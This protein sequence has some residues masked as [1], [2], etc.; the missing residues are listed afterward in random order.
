MNSMLKL[1]AQLS[2]LLGLL[3]IITGVVVKFVH[4]DIR[5]G[6][7]GHTM[8]LLSGSFFLCVLATRA[9]GR[10]PAEKSIDHQLAAKLEQP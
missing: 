5:L 4:L 8:F 6:V 9:I 10:M 7:A 1:L 2:W 3:S